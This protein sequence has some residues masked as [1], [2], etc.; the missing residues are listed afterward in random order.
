VGYLVFGGNRDFDAAT[1]G[2]DGVGVRIFRPTDEFSD[3][4]SLQNSRKI[5]FSAGKIVQ[6][7]DVTISEMFFL[8]NLIIA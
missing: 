4:F 1:S 5:R 8:L 6:K 7:I 2:R 3:L